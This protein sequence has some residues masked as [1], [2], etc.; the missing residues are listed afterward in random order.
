MGIV[1]DS[2]DIT[3]LSQGCLLSQEV[4]TSPQTEASGIQEV[5]SKGLGQ[6]PE[7]QFP[8]EK[9]SIASPAGREELLLRPVTGGQWKGLLKRLGLG[10]CPCPS[11]VL[12]NSLKYTAVPER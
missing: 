9:N 6:Q 2:S 5:V 11:P 10:P 8:Y 1:S 3:S 4:F 7:S 12:G